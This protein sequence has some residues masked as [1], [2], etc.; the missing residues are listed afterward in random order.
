LGVTRII[1]AE[2]A[3]AA[4]E[5]SLANTRPPI[6][7]ICGG[8]HIIIITGGEIIND[9]AAH[10]F[11]TRIRRAKVP[12]ITG[13]FS[14]TRLALS[15][16]ATIIEG[17]R[18]SVVTGIFVG[19]VYTPQDGVTTRI[20]AGIG[21][22]T[23]QIRLFTRDTT[24]LQAT[25]VSSTRVAIFTG[26]C[27]RCKDTG[28]ILT[29]VLCAHI[30]IEAIED[31][32]TGGTHSI[33]TGI[34]NAARIPII[35]GGLQ[36]SEHTSHSQLTRVYCAWIVVLTEGQARRIASTQQTTVSGGTRVTVI[37]VQS[38]IMTPF[39]VIGSGLAT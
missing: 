14:R 10:I 11:L 28:P 33:D 34:S 20:R 15:A 24:S 37:T 29:G 13:Q 1:R 30:P 36:G 21:I 18:V 12:I 38:I 16:A 23:A 31:Q 6:T 19:D 25:V 3:V 27:S 5:R 17:T 9:N 7:Q 2:I 32:F 26:P 39:G 8:A 22:L 35:T 4:F